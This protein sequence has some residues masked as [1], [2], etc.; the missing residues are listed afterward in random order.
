MQS[1]IDVSSP[2]SAA[3][4]AFSAGGIRPAPAPRPP[5]ARVACQLPHEYAPHAHLHGQLLFTTRG[6]L[7]LDVEGKR[8]IAPP[9]RALWIPPRVVHA[10]R[11]PD[12]VQLCSF[13]CGPALCARMPSTLCAMA[14]SP[15]LRELTA[16]V[17][18]LLDYSCDDGDALAQLIADELRVQ[19]Q[20][21]LALPMP[22]DR[23]LRKLCERLQ[24]EPH[25]ELPLDELARE[26]ALS[27]RHLA[28]LFR[29]ETGMSVAAW[30][31]QLRLS[32]SL[33]LLAGGMP[34]TQAAHQVGYRS[35]TTYAATFK[36]TFGV[37]PSQYFAAAGAP[38][39]GVSAASLPATTA[40]TGGLP[41]TGLPAATS[42][43]V[44]ASAR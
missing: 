32:M 35:P 16:R 11:L 19:A 1:V 44:A 21:P 9:L 6:V 5:A 12:D 20:M 33:V 4:R 31:Q 36:R 29:S 41:A 2:P 38:A 30:R 34:V 24:R 17:T 22:V 3:A 14:V 42:L 26:V 40:K 8:W 23:R 43:A 10:M 18:N 15:L 28:R 13:Y 7:V 27:P 25:C 37:A 39:E